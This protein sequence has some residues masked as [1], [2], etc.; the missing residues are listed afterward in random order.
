[1]PCTLP[2]IR[3]YECVTPAEAFDDIQAGLG[4]LARGAVL[5]KRDAR[6]LRD[7]LA[8]GYSV[9]SAENEDGADW[10]DQYVDA[11]ANL[12]QQLVSEAQRAGIGAAAVAG[13]EDAV[14][15]WPHAG[16]RD[17]L[18]RVCPIWPFC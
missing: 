17:V 3:Q 6:L 14:I 4:E 8:R 16:M 2:V 15:V 11:V 7:L 5:D 18:K 13:E 9:L 12:R 10:Q 1:M